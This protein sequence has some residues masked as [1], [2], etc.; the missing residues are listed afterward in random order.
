MKFLKKL[1]SMLTA[2]AAVLELLLAVVLLTADYFTPNSYTVT[3][4]SHLEWLSGAITVVGDSD[5]TAS[6]GVPYPKTYQGTMMLY[7]VIP[8]KAVDV[9]IV[10]QTCVVPCGTPFGI[11][12][13]TDGVVIVGLADIQTSDGSVNPAAQAGLK[14]GDVIT[15]VDGKKVD[16]NSEVAKDVEN[17]EGKSIRFSIR[18]N[19]TLSTVVLKPV[20]SET[21]GLYKAG[22]WVRDST[23]GIG[24]LTFYD[25]ST[26]SFAGLGHGICDSDTGEL[27]P[28][29]SG[30]IVPVTINGV[31]KGLKGKP[32]ELRGYFTDS[33]AMGRLVA[34]VTTGVYG[35]LESVPEGSALKVAMKQDVKTG[36]VKILTTIDGGIPKYYDAEIERIDYRDQVQSKNLVL[37][38]TDSGLV[39]QTGG[40]VQGMSGSPIIQNGK[41]IGAVTHVFVNDPTRGYGVFAENMLVEAKTVESAANSKAS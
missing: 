26:K 16:A 1:I 15:E 27:M 14:I 31:T 12:M 25:P 32:G 40:I 34:N 6:A 36:K 10:D 11:K 39:T 23:A 30:D 9:S 38:I 24:T 29:L 35:Y 37:H 28:L 7:N 17:C 2:S 13:F 20:R 3:N 33:N 41:L 22:L 21:D 4:G 8:I 18:R 19:G 5:V